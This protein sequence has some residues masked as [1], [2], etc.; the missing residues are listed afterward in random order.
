MAIIVSD[1]SS[2]KEQV[3][4]FIPED[5]FNIH[6][7]RSCQR[8]ANIMSSSKLV[9]EHLQNKPDDC[10]IV[11]QQAYRWRMDPFAVAQA[12]S[13]V[14]GKLC[15]EGKLVAA[16]LEALTKIELNYKYSGTGEKRQVIINR[17]VDPNPDDDVIV[18]WA[19]VKTDNQQ[20]KAD[21]DQM[22][23]YRGSRNWVRRHKPSV[24]MGIYTI[25]E[26]EAVK[27]LQNVTPNNDALVNAIMGKGAV[28]EGESSVP[29]GPR[30]ANKLDELLSG[31][32]TENKNPINRSPAELK[33]Q[34]I[35]S[36]L[37]GCKTAKDLEDITHRNE[38]HVLAMNEDLAL[39]V[40]VTIEECKKKFN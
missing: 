39:M 32:L 16:V 7:F 27:P 25:D 12:T 33:C 38:R 20:W 2:E 23:A 13:V 34:E 11:T 4:N 3:P 15:Y 31:G 22:L 17:K 40:E 10:F 18:V 37:H 8:I 9:P 6:V 14:R 28:I 21:P 26:M 30:P 1:K 19:N 29:T 5:V 35:I 24:L 36:A